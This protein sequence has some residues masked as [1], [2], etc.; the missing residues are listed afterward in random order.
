METVTNSHESIDNIFNEVIKWRPNL[1]S[2]P[3]CKESSQ[4]ISTLA[5]FYE[6][7]STITAPTDEILKGTV[8]FSKLILQK[9]V[10]INFTTSQDILF[11]LDRFDGSTIIKTASRIHGFDGNSAL[12]AAAWYNMLQKHEEQST[13]LANALAKTAILLR[14]QI[15]TDVQLY[16]VYVATPSAEDGII[17]GNPLAM[18]IYILT[19]VPMID[20]LKQKLPH[21]ESLWYAD[22]IPKYGFFLNALKCKILAFDK[23]L[24]SAKKLFS[25]T[26][27]SICESGLIILGS[28]IG[29]AEFVQENVCKNAEELSA[30]VDELATVAVVDPHVAYVAQTISL[31]ARCQHQFALFGLPEMQDS[32]PKSWMHYG[33]ADWG[34]SSGRT[35]DPRVYRK[36]IPEDS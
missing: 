23:S 20:I 21:A 1:F 8:V 13:R 33:I 30:L 26:E 5:S 3:G 17:Q 11:R 4:F 10:D 25:H 35:I 24:E 31:Q 9:D 15:S 12:D 18:P 16:L 29:S 34:T 22:D 14:L 36:P 28:P 7:F 2:I 32:Q 27:I 6:V 19:I